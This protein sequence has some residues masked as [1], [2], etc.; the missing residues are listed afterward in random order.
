MTKLDVH[1]AIK[2]VVSYIQQINCT[3]KYFIQIIYYMFIINR[4][5]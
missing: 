5:F 1:S 4:Y 2:N 3:M